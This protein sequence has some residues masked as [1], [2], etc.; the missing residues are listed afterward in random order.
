MGTLCHHREGPPSPAP[1]ALPLQLGQ[2]GQNQ[3]G[4]LHIPSHR[5]SRHR[6]GRSP[7]KGSCPSSPPAA[8]LPSTSRG[9]SPAAWCGYTPLTGR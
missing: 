4:S 3:A 1:P 7:G 9:A 6:G 2:A 5:A 8:A